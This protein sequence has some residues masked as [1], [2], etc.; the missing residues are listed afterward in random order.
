MS[1]KPNQE[2][3]ETASKGLLAQIFTGP[4]EA[5]PGADKTAQVWGKEEVHKGD[6][7]AGGHLHQST[8]VLLDNHQGCTK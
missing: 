4:P 5:V 7:E 8:P 1:K 6:M 2:T 3:M